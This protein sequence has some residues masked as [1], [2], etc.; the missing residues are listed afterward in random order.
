MKIFAQVCAGM[1]KSCGYVATRRILAVQNALA[2]QKVHD[3]SSILHSDFKLDAQKIILFCQG[4]RQ[5]SLPDLSVQN[6]H[7]LPISEE[8]VALA[9]VQLAHNAYFLQV[10]QGLVH[11]SHGET[12][13]FGKPGCGDYGAFL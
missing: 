2:S 10:G 8:P 9:V 7:I 1:E 11:C 13:L 6:I 12:C 3:V 5:S 4:G